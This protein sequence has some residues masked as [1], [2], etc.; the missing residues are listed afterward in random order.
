MFVVVLSLILGSSLVYAV[1]DTSTDTTPLNKVGEIKKDFKNM[2]EENKNLRDDIKTKRD[3]LKNTI[4][5]DKE[6]FKAIKEEKKT[7]LES[8]IG[9]IKTK[10]EEFKKQMESDK[11]TLKTKI[12]AIKAEFKTNLAKIKDEKKKAIVDNVT[13]TLNDLNTKL[14]GQLADKVDQIETVLVSIQSRIDKAETKGLYVSA[15]KTQVTKAENAIK[16]AR[17]AITTQSTK[18]YTPTLSDETKLKAEMQTLRD[19]FK[20]DIKAVFEKVKLAHQAVVDTAGTLA[21]IPNVND[22][23]TSVEN[24]TPTTPETTN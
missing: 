14:T 20:T 2:R 4:K 5:Q 17:S 3:E 8:L 21:K 24:T 10:R 22:T 6:D 19:T 15:V 13:T 1:E 16:D 11:E 7:E 23:P 9:D 18:D 12:E